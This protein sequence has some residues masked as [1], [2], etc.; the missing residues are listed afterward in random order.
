MFIYKKKYIEYFVYETLFFGCI[1]LCEPQHSLRVQNA[2]N[3]LRSFFWLGK[4]FKN[5]IYIYIYIYI[6]YEEDL[7]N[8]EKQIG[9]HT[10][11]RIENFF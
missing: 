7:Y 4:A 8:E 11:L 9:A 1:H 5:I 3:L 10:N 2:S 6:K